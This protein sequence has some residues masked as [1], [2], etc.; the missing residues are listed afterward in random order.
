[1]SELWLRAQ[2][3][4][5]D[6]RLLFEKSRYNSACNRAYYAMF[7]AAR[8]LLLRRGISTADAKRHTTVWRQFSLHFVKNGPFE[9]AEGGS[10]SQIGDVRL[11]VDY[12]GQLIDRES[13]EAVL[14]SM[15]RFMSA[16]GRI[17][18]NPDA[19]AIP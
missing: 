6:A 5:D 9:I 10:L 8:A 19:E 4:A 14:D 1:M 16:A 13:A 2:E 11:A 18:Q 12:A 3:Y 17:L 7:N 15:E